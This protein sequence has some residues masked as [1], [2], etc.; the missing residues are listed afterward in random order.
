M[1][2]FSPNAPPAGRSAQPTPRRPI[3]S[4]SPAHSSGRRSIAP[5]PPSSSP[6]PQ[7]PSSTGAK[8]WARSSARARSST[9]ATLVYQYAHAVVT[10][11]SAQPALIGN[12]LPEVPRQSFTAQL[13]AERRSLG[14]LT[15]AARARGHAWDDRA[16]TYLLNS[17]FQLDLFACHNFGPRWTASVIL[18]NLLNQRPDVAR[19]PI[20]TLGSPF[21]AQAGLAFH[22]NG[23]AAH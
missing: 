6:A 12:W 21:L 16:N 3:S 13:R 11:C 18:N 8:T 7:P 14:S 1:R 4:P 23:T 22:W 17:F 9:S 20:L 10:Q 19:T 15:L 5:S 2:S